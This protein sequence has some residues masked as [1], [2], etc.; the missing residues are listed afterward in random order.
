MASSK[1]D[2]G[3]AFDIPVGSQGDNVAAGPQ[4]YYYTSP[5]RPVPGQWPEDLSMIDE[6]TAP[7][8]T[9]GIFST[10]GRFAT[11]LTLQMFKI[12]ERLIKRFTRSQQI[13]VVPVIREDG[14]SKRRLIDAGL[15]PATPTRK[16]NAAPSQDRD[17]TRTPSLWVV[18]P[19]T[20]D[21]NSPPYSEDL[22]IDDS[23]D[24]SMEDVDSGTPSHNP[25]TGSPTGVPWLRRPE[26]RIITPKSRV[27]SPS[28]NLPI[29]NPF[30]AT[31]MRKQLLKSQLRVV[32][33][34]T[35]P[36]SPLSRQY[37]HL[38]S[39]PTPNLATTETKQN[40]SGP[41]IFNT[42]TPTVAVRAQQV[43]VQDEAELRE[44]RENQATGARATT[45]QY[46]PHPVEAID[47][48]LSHLPDATDLSS[49]FESLRTP[50]P[51]SQKKTIRWAAQGRVKSYY[52]DERIS[53]MLD[54]TLESIRSPVP[55]PNF[56]DEED[57]EAE[58]GH[59]AEEDH[60]DEE[61]NE[62]KNQYP[63]DGSL[64]VIYEEPEP[65]SDSDDS[66]DGPS[67]EDPFEESQ[68]SKELLADLEED[69]KNLLSQAPPPPP[70]P[71][72]LIAP[73]TDDERAKLDDLATKSKHGQNESYPIIPDKISARDFG[74]LLPDQFNGNAKAWLN[75]EIV[76]QY[77]TTIIKTL[78]DDCAFVY[79]RGGPAPP[80]HAFSSHWY[81]SI[82][83]GVKKV[84]R[85]AGR[86]GLGGKQFLDAK[87]VFFP[88]CDGS[89]WRLLAVKPQVRT[90]EYMD[91]L[92]WDGSKYVAKFLEYLQH[93]LKE[94]WNADEW[95]VVDL[96]RSS[97]QLNGSDCGVFV[98]LNALV[99]VRGEEAKKVVAC[100][101]MLE[102]RER[103]AITI[104]T[105]HPVELDY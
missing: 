43:A 38:A 104:I 45:E 29:P 17:V 59:E 62:H 33:T 70:P 47:V 94:S 100:N 10:L 15:A 34:V 24:W 84:E 80:Y 93:E 99:V 103:L 27:I 12:P 44:A 5:P 91:S 52:V 58:E 90:I 41:S 35:P 19:S 83:G 101:G 66:V 68:L 87:V 16:V 95:T 97:R 82:K 36:T 32:D 18:T 69:F 102:A 46:F 28:S 3:R 81:N 25:R 40:T 26:R 92:G 9:G 61:D 37:D 8:P 67:L 13:R 31:P 56:E 11:S 76:N 77:L 64:G 72:P 49:S 42:N 96:Q 73:L 105:G 89:H 48:D 55:K 14:A 57:H 63:T 51:S 6:A 54:S 30:L 20:S 4:A 60:E 23:L 86:V 22:D 50:S 71:K 88:I 39:S 53:E 21:F 79:K 85:W 98:L 1:R 74:T 75:D 78:N 7:S 65:N 2:F